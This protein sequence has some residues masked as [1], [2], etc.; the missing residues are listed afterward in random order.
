MDNGGRLIPYEY[1]GNGREELNYNSSDNESSSSSE[2]DAYEYTQRKETFYRQLFNSPLKKIR[3]SVHTINRNNLSDPTHS[4]VVDLKE[5]NIGLFK[6][7]VGFNVISVSI[8]YSFYT[9][10]S[11][12]NKIMYYTYQS[13]DVDISGV[14]ATYNSPTIE[15]PIGVYTS[16]TL[17]TKIINLTAAIT[18]SHAMQDFTC[19][20]DDITGLF[21]FSGKGLYRIFTF[22]ESLTK[23]LGL[24]K[25][26]TDTPNL[27]SITDPIDGETFNG[28]ILA[29]NNVP[30]YTNITLT[31]PFVADIRGT[32]CIDLEINEIPSICCIY[33]DYSNNIVA[34]IPIDSTYG[35]IINYH[36]L[37]TDLSTNKFYP[38][39]L[40]TLSLN[41][42][43]ENGNILNLNG[44]D[45]HMIC[46]ATVLGDL[47]ENF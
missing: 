32:T 15:I 44:T 34:R 35:S 47:P 8:P 2:E 7:V 26:T 37:T 16:I 38:I 45:F 1:S 3:F 25:I 6:Q 31:S 19:I 14:I 18:S 33:T 29:S 28:G 41:L 13:S 23:I 9:I 17:A 40:S 5:K 36:S 22:S 21:K 20:Y 39:K 11:N 43:D 10:T 42:L 12:N 27:I 30:T 46:E 4:C 24:Q